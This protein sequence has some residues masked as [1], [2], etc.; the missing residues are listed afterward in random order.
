MIVNGC[1]VWDLCDTYLV[2]VTLWLPQQMS[3]ITQF[4]HMT[5][6][7]SL[8]S[9][10][11][12]FSHRLPRRQTFLEM[13][14]LKKYLNALDNWRIK[15]KVFWYFLLSVDIFIVRVTMCQIW[16]VWTRNTTQYVPRLNISISISTQR[17]WARNMTQYQPRLRAAPS[18]A[19]VTL[20]FES[21]TLTLQTIG[22]IIG[23]TDN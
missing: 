19:P 13:Q 6:N 2:I 15:S 10:T 16:R 12:Q 8:S 14:P 21:T 1:V 17:V 5:R 4:P 22:A 3:L 18:P 23:N 11:P 9:S 20:F 7:F